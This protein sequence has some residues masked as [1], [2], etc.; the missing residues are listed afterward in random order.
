[1]ALYFELRIS[2]LLH[3]TTCIKGDVRRSIKIYREGALHAMYDDDELALT[4]AR[5]R[6]SSR[7]ADCPKRLQSPIKRL[8]LKD[9]FRQLDSSVLIRY[10]T[11]GCLSYNCPK[12]S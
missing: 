2:D 5:S 11:T 10:I 3:N 12:Y 9:L 1:M 4:L 7:R 6:R 8:W